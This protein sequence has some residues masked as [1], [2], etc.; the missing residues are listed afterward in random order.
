MKKWVLII[1]IT[2]FGSKPF[3]QSQ[4]AQQLLLNWEKLTQLKKIL[5]DMYTG[6][7]I[8]HKGYTTIKDISQGNFT[9]HKDFLDGLLEVSPAVKNYKRI[10]D[11]I[12]YQLRIVKG[13]K[14]AFNQFKLST[15][16]TAEEIEY[17]GRVYSNLLKESLKC[18]DELAMVITA[19]KLRMSDDE[20]LQAIDRIYITIVE[21]FSFLQ[22]FNNST[23]VL[24]FQR[25]KDYQDIDISRKLHNIRE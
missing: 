19:G 6:Y 13:Y 25:E 4:E 5:N 17:L 24:S 9:L 16:F 1:I 12:S 10:A 2:A 21:Q 11:I 3:G 23:A 8:V 7:K 18:L 14:T 22:E 20:R 15:Y